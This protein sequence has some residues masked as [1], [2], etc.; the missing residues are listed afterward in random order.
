VWRI[1]SGMVEAVLYEGGVSGISLGP[2]SM[3]GVVG[4]VATV[5]EQVT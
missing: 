5:P 1:A 2:I 3:L 4:R